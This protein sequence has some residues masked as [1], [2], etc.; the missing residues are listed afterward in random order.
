[1][2]ET[3]TTITYD[4]A[5][6]KILVKKC[7]NN[8]YNKYVYVYNVNGKQENMKHENLINKSDLVKDLNETTVDLVNFLSTLT[9]E[10]NFGQ[11]T[12]LSENFKLS[13]ISLLDYKPAEENKNYLFS[14]DEILMSFKNVN[15]TVDYSV[16]HSLFVSTNHLNVHTIFNSMYNVCKEIVK[17]NMNKNDIISAYYVEM[18]FM[19]HF[20]TFFKDEEFEQY[21]KT[22]SSGNIQTD[23]LFKS[24]EVLVPNKIVD[25]YGKCSFINLSNMLRMWTSYGIV[26]TIIMKLSSVINVCLSR[27]AAHGVL[28]P[29][30]HSKEEVGEARTRNVQAFAHDMNVYGNRIIEPVKHLIEHM[31]KESQLFTFLLFGIS[32][33]NTSVTINFSH[34]SKSVYWIASHNIVEIGKFNNMYKLNIAISLPVIYY[35]NLFQKCRDDSTHFFHLPILW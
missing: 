32:V 2:E 6:N 7:K 25:S 29:K 27:I 21:A 24:V 10:N 17:T 8:I 16:F 33:V 4:D 13:D 26:E 3:T 22:G 30:L 35:F 14:G 11:Y 23:E 18:L 15:S 1:M 12:T 20:K 28:D 31:W 9:G 34:L 19:K 5:K